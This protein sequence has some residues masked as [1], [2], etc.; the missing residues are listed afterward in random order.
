M[1]SFSYQQQE[2][3]IMQRT[4]IC[5]WKIDSLERPLPRQGTAASFYS[6]IKP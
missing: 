6:T 5:K 1:V 2:D 3:V 4:K